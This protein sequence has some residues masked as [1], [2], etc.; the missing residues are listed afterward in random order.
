MVID[1]RRLFD[2]S[3]RVVVITGGTRGLGR[4]LAEGYVMAGARVVVVS[5]TS[6]ACR[7]TEEHLRSQGGDAIGIPADVGRLE[8]LAPIVEQTVAAFGALDVLVN[9]AGTGPRHTVGKYRY[10]DWQQV[11]AVNAVGPVFLMQEALPYLKQSDHAAVLNVLSS[12]AF[13]TSE[14]FPI[15]GASKAALFAHTRSAAAELAQYGIRVNG[16]APGPF[17]TEILGRQSQRVQD[18]AASL[19][20]QKRIADPSEVVGAA[21]LLTSDA[22]SFITGQVLMVDGGVVTAR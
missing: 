6:E 10:D 19:T 12:G 13:L 11:F 21:L 1:Y 14:Q 3:G 20:L 2:M 8:D 15:Y 17:A 5:R 18:F 9:N 4:A 7:D 22:G 16:I